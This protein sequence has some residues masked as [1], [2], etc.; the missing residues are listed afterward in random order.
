MYSALSA[1]FHSIT[2]PDHLVT[3]KDMDNT[4]SEQT[5]SSVTALTGGVRLYQSNV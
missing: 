5:I 3:D 4:N 1:D 2:R